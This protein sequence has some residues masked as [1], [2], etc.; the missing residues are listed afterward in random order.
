MTNDP[1]LSQAHLVLQIQD[2]EHRIVDPKP[3]VE[4]RISSAVMVGDRARQCLSPFA[5]GGA[6]DG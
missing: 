3:Y 2:G 5:G 4:A 1:S 6:G